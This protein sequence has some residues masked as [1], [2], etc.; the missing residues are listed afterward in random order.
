[1]NIDEA[2][3]IMEK[4]KGELQKILDKIPVMKLKKS[5]LPFS[6][7]KLLY[8]KELEDKQAIANELQDEIIALDVLIEFAKATFKK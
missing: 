1:M 2:I 5:K 8:Y 4:R 7:H 6:D 3:S